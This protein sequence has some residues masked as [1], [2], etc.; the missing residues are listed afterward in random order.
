MFKHFK[1]CKHQNGYLLEADYSDPLWCI[2]CHMN[3]DIEELPIPL[4][5]KLTDELSLWSFRYV[6]LY[7]SHS[8][9][10]QNIQEFNKEG[11]ALFKKIQAELGEQLQVKYKPID[12]DPT[13]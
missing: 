9:T 1:K 13:I 4:S 7:N 3:H 6:Q 10:N 5:E 12:F 2:D 11:E 8:F